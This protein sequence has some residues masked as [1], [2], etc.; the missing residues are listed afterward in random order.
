MAVIDSNKLFRLEVKRPSTGTTNTEIVHLQVDYNDI[1]G[2]PIVF[3]HYS[4][5]PAVGSADTIYIALEDV[6]PN[7]YCNKI[8]L[9]SSTSNSYICIG[10]DTPKITVIDGGAANTTNWGD[11]I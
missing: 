10:A 6:T 1:E 5:F 3:D 4:N 9:W 8:Y 11:I 7:N 2:K